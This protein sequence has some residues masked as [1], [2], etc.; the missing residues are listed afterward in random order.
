MIARHTSAPRRPGARALAVPAVL[1]LLAVALAPTGANAA[2]APTVSAVTP[3]PTTT[4][5]ASTPAPAAG[6]AAAPSTGSS[7]T[8]PATPATSAASTPAP[9]STTAARP[10][11][12]A[13]SKLSTPAIALAVLAALL[14]LGCLAWGLARTLAYEPRWVQSLRHALAE[15]GFRASATWAEFT[16]WARLGR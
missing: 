13:S 9:T 6:G 5:A 11:S 12:H 2:T 1:A 7:A 8:T 14:A 10:R 3:A 16:D 15:A 4:P